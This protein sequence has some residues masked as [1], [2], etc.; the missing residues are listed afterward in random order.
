M[1]R[2]KIKS[3]KKYAES[4]INTEYIGFARKTESDVKKL[5]K[6]KEYKV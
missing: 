1:K 5:E 6:E 3:E 4:K 2:K